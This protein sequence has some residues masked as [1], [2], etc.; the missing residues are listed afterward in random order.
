M[1]TFKVKNVCFEESERNHNWL[2]INVTKVLLFVKVP[3][4]FLTSNL[5]S[6]ASFFNEINSYFLMIFEG[7]FSG[8]QLFTFVGLQFQSFHCC[9][10]FALPCL[11]TRLLIKDHSLPLNHSIKCDFQ[12]YNLCFCF[13]LLYQLQNFLLHIKHSISSL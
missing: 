7:G 13:L 6:G 2:T 3:I 4:F 10:L 8:R 5:P 12:W 1:F 9:Q 11:L